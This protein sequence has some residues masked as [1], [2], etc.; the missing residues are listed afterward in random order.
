MKTTNHITPFSLVC[1]RRFSLGLTVALFSLSFTPTSAQTV[2]WIKQLGTNGD[3]LS[4]NV[5][6]DGLGNVYIT[7]IT[8]GSLGGSNA[9]NYDAFLCKYNS[10]GTLLWTKQ[11]GTSSWDRSN[12]VF[13]DD[14]GNVYISGRTRGSLEG[15]SAG[16]NDVFLQKYNAAGTLLWTNQF[17]KSQDDHSNSVSVDDLGNVYISGTTYSS[18]GGTNAGSLDAFI[19]KF[20][21]SGTLLWTKQ[22][23]TRGNDQSYA[24]SVDNLGNAYMT[25]WTNGTLGRS[26]Y[27]K[28][29]AF[30]S[31]YDTLGMLCWT[32]QWGSSSDD[33]G[34]DVLADSLGNVYMTG[35]TGTNAFLNKY[36]DSGILLWSETLGTNKDD[37]SYS[38]STDGLGNVYISGITDGSLGGPNAGNGDVFL[39]KYDTS[40]TLLW[41]EQMG[42]NGEDLGYGVSSDGLGNVYITGYTAGNLGGSYA[43]GRDVFIGKIID[44]PEPSLLLLAIFGITTLAVFRRR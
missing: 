41:T 32:M 38:L 24:V 42:T 20:N 2:E 13:A 34:Y 10:S 33:H 39:S 15:L 1:C 14:L 7:G 4:Y 27:G 43:G 3:D 5:S 25:G 28:Y 9:G 22:L 23:G 37:I 21:T 30:L 11:L 18:L 19:S 17:G 12:D 16:Q 44:V 35:N 31:K 8:N 26:K 36:D 29:D 40:G 6:A